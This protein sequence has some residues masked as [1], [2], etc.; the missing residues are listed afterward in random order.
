[1]HRH[2]EQSSDGFEERGPCT[3]DHLDP[4]IF[5]GAVERVRHERYARAM[6]SRER[7]PVAAI[8]FSSIAVLCAAGAIA[9]VV[10]R[11]WTD[12]GSWILLAV[13]VV[14]LALAIV[15]AVPTA[16]M[17]RRLPGRPKM[18][19][20]A[21]GA[22]MTA[23]GMLIMAGA[24]LLTGAGPADLSVQ[25]GLGGAVVSGLVVAHAYRET[26]DPDDGEDS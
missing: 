16:A 11:G 13:L 8:L 10:R 18:P 2:E 4:P 26:D 6:A 12:D 5:G 22:S 9:L 1:M 17:E 3:G 20:T 25:L 21:T 15:H 14:S 24:A 23:A 19:R 7:N